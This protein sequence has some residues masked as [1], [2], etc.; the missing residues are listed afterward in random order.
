MD[1]STLPK[2]L[3]YQQKTLDKISELHELNRT[4]L[5]NILDIETLHDVD[6]EK[7]VLP[8][9]NN[10][11]Y[12]CTM[13]RMEKNA[14]FRRNNYKKIALNGNEKNTL[15]QCVTLSLVSILNEH[16]SFEWLVKFHIVSDD[17]KRYA[18]SLWIERQ[19]E[20]LFPFS[21]PSD[22]PVY[23]NEMVHLIGMP[24]AMS[25]GIDNNVILPEELFAP[26]HID[27]KALRDMD[28]EN[29][30]F[31]W[32]DWTKYYDEEIVRELVEG[33]GT[34]QM[35]KAMLI[36]SLWENSNSFYHNDYP[37][38]HVEPLLKS[39]SEEF[40]PDC[41]QMTNLYPDESTETTTAD[42]TNLSIKNQATV[43]PV[44]DSEQQSIIE[45]Q[46]A[47]I[48]ELEAEVKKLK[49]KITQTTGDNKQVWI[50]WL[51]WDVFHSS[52]K[53]EE[54]YNSIDKI[55][56][57]E[58]GEKAKCYALY[59]IMK[60]IKW[61]KKDAAQKDLLKWWSAHFDCDWHSD[62]Q[63]KF[64]ELPNTIR[65]ATTTDQWKDCGGNNNEYYYSYAQ[66]L[67]KAFVWN[68]GRGQYET[69]PQFVKAGCLPPE[70]CK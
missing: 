8:C 60:E 1:Y 61:L 14:A 27:E 18:K 42:T 56:T 33:L 46:S 41:L 25:R 67:K 2:A 38:Q 35:D 17:L 11:Y 69:K 37:K 66:D 6:F 31:G 29:H 49:Q 15:M 63:L 10:A 9:F 22:E 50:D 68:K 36:R 23:N 7:F 4:I 24:E 39:L 57:P 19:S 34:T 43:S 65:N 5:N 54:V 28:I 3:I 45:K 12:I 47:R 16:C 70:K 30:S 26:R 13:M 64:T 55:A 53:A 51:D 21:S 59:R 44:K 40:C 20:I 52:I 62:N 32:P 48:E 58:L